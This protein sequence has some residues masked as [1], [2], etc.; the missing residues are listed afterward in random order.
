[1]PNKET[2]APGTG[3]PS[4]VTT[5]PA[6]AVMRSHGPNAQQPEAAAVMQAK[7]NV[8]KTLKDAPNYK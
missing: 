4:V 5:R 3:A 6:I 1:M 8:L 7:R 2:F